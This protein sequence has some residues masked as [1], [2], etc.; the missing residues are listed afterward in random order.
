MSLSPDAALPLS[1]KFSAASTEVDPQLQSPLFATLCPEL[2]NLVFAYAL[3]EYDDPAGPSQYT[4]RI[5]TALLL[6]CRLIYLET[7]SAPIS[8]N[9]HTFWML[10][11][12]LPQGAE[13]KTG[14]SSSTPAADHNAYFTR[15]TLEQRSAVQR[16]R[17]FTEVDWL[18]SLRHQKWAEGL[19][20]PNLTVTVVSRPTASEAETEMAMGSLLQPASECDDEDGGNASGWERW[21][22]SVPHLRVFEL[23]VE[24]LGCKFRMSRAD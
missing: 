7:H 15:M 23:E 4:G 2:R 18:E 20:V 10:D 12:T 8:L 17:F 24:A 1:A 21:V 13:Q 16:V 5:D 3:T 19:A 22:A 14:S 11:R 6:T 9:E